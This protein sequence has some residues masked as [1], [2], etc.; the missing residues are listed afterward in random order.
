M[1]GRAPG[2]QVM[3][4]VENDL[5]HNK[6]SVEFDGKAGG[7]GA[8]MRSMCIGLVF[9]PESPS[10]AYTT[11]LSGL[12][13][14]PNITAVMGGCMASVFTALAFANVSV[15]TWPTYF[16]QQIPRFLA[17]IF[18]LRPEWRYLDAD[19]HIHYVT[20]QLEMYIEERFPK[21]AH[22]PQFPSDWL[23]NWKK[24]DAFYSKFAY[25]NNKNEGWN[26][27]SGHDAVIIAYDCYL[28]RPDDW[29]TIV[30]LAALHGG[31]SDSTASIAGA[32]FGARH[33]IRSETIQGLEYAPELQTIADRL[34]EFYKN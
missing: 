4:A 10:L 5:Q 6:V 26:G 15:E 13:T 9:E 11:I 19:T 33:G 1:K 21:N 25:K 7:N 20:R 22:A 31:D 27:S 14:H 28:Y 29:D 24:R 32:F 16:F 23:S 2:A 17:Y 3:R 34:F 18:K 12:L 8:A 30:H